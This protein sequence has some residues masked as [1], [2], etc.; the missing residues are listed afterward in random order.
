MT[1]FR[2]KPLQSIRG[3][4]VLVAILGILASQVNL[5]V[6]SK[7][8]MQSAS[9]ED[10]TVSA[11]STDTAIGYTVLSDQFAFKDEAVP[12]KIAVWYPSSQKKSGHSTGT[13]PSHSPSA[14]SF[15]SLERAFNPGPSTQSDPP[16]ETSSP[17]VAQTHF[18]Y[19]IG[20]NKI[21]SDL[22]LNAP[23]A[24]GKFP[25]VFYSHGATGAGTSSFFIC[26]LLARN[27]Y[28]V[29]AP[30]FLDTVFVAR[31]DQPVP[32][33]GFLWM[34][35]DQYISWL[36]ELGLNKASREGRTLFE[37]RPMQLKQTMEKVFVLNK[38]SK[39]A[40]FNHVDEDRIGLF[41]HSFGAWTSVL[42]AGA[43]PTFQDKRVKAVVALSGPVNEHVYAVASENDLS[44]VNVPILFEFG[45]QEP[46]KGRKDDKTFLFDKSKSPKQLISI[47]GADHLSFSGGVKGE[48]KKASEY[49]TE[50]P[51]RKT[52]SETTLDFFNAFIKG[53]AGSKAKLKDRSEGVASS[54]A[55][56]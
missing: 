20:S 2:D 7:E 49:L 46:A 22:V 25:V 6:E 38:D 55:D 5:Q 47:K 24:E 48:H 45:D 35:T 34:R 9:L 11:S 53:D 32:Y 19:P 43:S 16:R 10:A 51:Q 50:D 18:A 23:V 3:L 28:I 41:G 12:F 30:D 8:P 14:D 27:G 15:S 29:V 33:D 56:F 26:E 40:L 54:I 21:E 42:L 39:S 37:Y 13:A 1:N 36:R 17:P 44:A 31:I 52:I 4:P